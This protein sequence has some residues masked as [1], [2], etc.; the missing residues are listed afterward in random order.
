MSADAVARRAGLIFAATLLFWIVA[1]LLL[2]PLPQPQ[3]YHAFAD[4]RAFAG[5]AN[6]WNVAS[7]VAILLA[8]LLGLGGVLRRPE[9][10]VTRSEIWPYVCFFAATTLVAL[11][12]TYYHLAPDNARLL[13]DRLPI[14]LATAVLPIALLSDHAGPKVALP[15]VL[16][17]LLAGALS[18]I[19]WRVSA[20]H[21]HENLVPYLLLQLLAVGAVVLL[22][23]RPG[24][25]TRTADWWSVIGLYV[26]ARLAEVFDAAIYAAGRILSGHTLKHLVAA[27]AAFWVLRM[28]RLRRAVP[29]P[30]TGSR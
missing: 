21:G 12:S 8:G 1:C 19:Y 2:P 26:V 30:A 15:L 16:P 23:S 28:I 10:F 3:S 4:A 5:I 20:V 11:G 18:A 9:R 7:N 25:Y 22:A 17:A 14:A 13:W 6:F 27:L 29:A 24:R